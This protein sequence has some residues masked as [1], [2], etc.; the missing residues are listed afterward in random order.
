MKITAYTRPL[1]LI[2]SP[3]T[4]SKSPQMLNKVCEILDI[5]ATYLAYAVEPARLQEAVMGMKALGFIGFN[6][7]IPHKV[8]IIPFLDE[9]DDTAKEI[10]AVNTV[11][12][13]NG[14]LVGFN[15]DGVGYLRSLQEETS[16]SIE[17][18]SI[19]IIGAGGAARAVSIT[20]AKSGAKEIIIANRTLEKAAELADIANKWTKATA[21]PLEAIKPS[22]AGSQLLVNTTSI[23]MSPNIDE[24]P[25]LMNFLHRD[26]LVSDLIY[27]PRETKLLQYAKSVGALT[28]G[29]LG[30]LLYQAAVAVE[31]WFNQSPPVNQMR[32]ILE[33]ED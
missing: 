24:S 21:V 12:N 14:R 7:T 15:T 17:D 30:M 4:H 29:G 33:N 22:I 16:F 2:G 5:P 13:D 20:L 6:V 10:G 23:G 3:V 25:I 31:H 28:H 8:A 32:A 19:T 9:L 27:R 1:G 18:K 11:V 26:L